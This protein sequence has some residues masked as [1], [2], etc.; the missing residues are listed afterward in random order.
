MSLI[1][2]DFRMTGN[3]TPP[4]RDTNDTNREIHDTQARRQPATIRFGDGSDVTF[5]CRHAPRAR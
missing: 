2:Q 5:V 1:T 3:E 4:W